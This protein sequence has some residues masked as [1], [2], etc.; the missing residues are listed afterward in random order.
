MLLKCNN[1][2]HFGEQLGTLPQDVIAALKGK[3][4]EGVA[5]A[6]VLGDNKVPLAVRNKVARLPWGWGGLRRHAW[7]YIRAQQVQP[8]QPDRRS[9][10]FW[11]LDVDAVYRS[12]AP[13]WNDFR[14]MAVSFGDV[15]ETEFI[16]TPFS[17]EVDGPPK[18]SDYVH[19]LPQ[20]NGKV[21]DTHSPAP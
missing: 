7:L 10:S 14:A 8:D 1:T 21:F 5:P 4:I 15:A 18:S 11:H 3:Q 9:G 20:L 6:D 16:S 17:I 2:H 12:V 13:D 19:L